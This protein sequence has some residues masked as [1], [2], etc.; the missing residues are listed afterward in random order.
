MELPMNQQAATQLIQQANIPYAEFIRNNVEKPVATAREIPKKNKR[1]T[2]R[3]P[4]ENK[5]EDDLELEEAPI[6]KIRKHQRYQLVQQGDYHG[7]Y[8][9]QDGNLVLFKSL[10]EAK[11]YIHNLLHHRE[12]FTMFYGGKKNNND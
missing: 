4:V 8:D 1:P 10:L 3:S 12:S 5:N 11:E 9:S 6:E 2:A 7:C